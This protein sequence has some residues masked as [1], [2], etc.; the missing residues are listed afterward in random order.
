MQ[1]KTTE[2]TLLLAKERFFDKGISPEEFRKTKMSDIKD[3]M[4][5]GEAWNA[6]A[7]RERKLQEAVNSMH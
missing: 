6:K 7:E 4:E 1:T 3:V 5:V 2:E